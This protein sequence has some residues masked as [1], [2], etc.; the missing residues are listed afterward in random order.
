MRANAYFILYRLFN[1]IFITTGATTPENVF[2]LP[3][4][5]SSPKEI[6]AL[7]DSDL[8]FAIDNLEWTTPQ[9]GRWTQAS[10][11]HLRAKTAMWQNDWA[12]AVAQTEAVIGNENYACCPIRGTY[13]PETSTTA[14]RCLPSRS[15][16]G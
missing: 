5:K 9:F 1:N 6:F 8:E 15:K 4:D 14:R 12:E 2:D 11:R 7:I 3:Q 10:A 16:T 13:L